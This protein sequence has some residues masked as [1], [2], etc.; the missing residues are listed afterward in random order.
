MYP[1]RN[2]PNAKRRKKRKSKMK[3]SYIHL[4]VWN[5]CDPK[6]P[7]SQPTTKAYSTHCAVFKFV[8][9]THEQDEVLKPRGPAPHP[10]LHQNRLKALC[11]KLRQQGESDETQRH[12]SEP[13]PGST[14]QA[15]EG[16]S[17]HALLPMNSSS[18][19]LPMVRQRG[20]GWDSSSGDVGPGE[21]APC[22]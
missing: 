15:R 18:C 21:S 11:S 3:K 7:N 1:N 14:H 6:P 13:G 16:T 12:S 5:D 19:G 10:L 22:P 17:A 20:V 2:I 9:C 4:P 8:S